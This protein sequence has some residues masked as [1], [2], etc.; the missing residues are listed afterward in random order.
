M[1]NIEVRVGNNTVDGVAIQPSNNSL[2][3]TN[4]VNS[5]TPYNVNCSTPLVGRYVS[6]QRTGVGTTYMVLCEVEV[7]AVPSAAPAPP[8]STEIVN[9]AF[10]KTAYHISS[11]A[12]GYG[13]SKAVDGIRT[14]DW[15]STTGTCAMSVG[16]NPWW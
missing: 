8:V 5:Y 2:C 3:G 6:V 16:T 15:S 14:T 1:T 9:L 7:F 4:S 12:A 13:A 10:N 11:A